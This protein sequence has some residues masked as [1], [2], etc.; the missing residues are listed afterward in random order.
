MF[1]HGSVRA[2]DP[3]EEYLIGEIPFSSHHITGHT[4]STHVM[5]GDVNLDHLVGIMLPDF[6]IKLLFFSFSYLILGHWV[7]KSSPYLSFTFRRGNICLYY[8]EFFIKEDL[9]PLSHLFVYSTIYL[10]QQG[11]MHIYFKC[12]LW[13]N[14]MLFLFLFKLFQVW[15]LTALLCCLLYSFALLPSFIFLALP[16]FLVLQMPQA[17]LVFSLLESPTS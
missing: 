7:T 16:C 1:S 3:K 12:E 6:S 2:M 14:T 8:L 5:A 15:S 11:L 13:F 9:S 4:I 10:H 17:H